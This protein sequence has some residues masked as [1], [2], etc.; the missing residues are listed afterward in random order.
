MISSLPININDLLLFH[1][2]ESARTEFKQSWDEKTTGVQI[3]KTICA[4]A[5]DFY[6]V[7]GGY[8][9]IGVAET[10]GATI[11]PP[12]GLSMEELN[13]AQKWIRGNCKR[14][15]PKVQLRLSPE[16]VDGQHILVVWIPGSDAR[17]H[18]APSGKNQ[19]RAY[20]I[21]EGSETIE[22][23]GQ[24]LTE[25]LNLCA[26]IPF[27]DRRA[28]Q[29]TLNDLRSILVRE[30]LSEVDSGLLEEKNDYK[31]YRHLW[32]TAKTNGHE[33][34]KNVALLFFT[35]DP[36]IAF[37][38]AR[39]EVVY[40]P[41]DSSGNLLQEWIFKGPLPKQ[42]KD[43]INHLEHFSTTFI[44]K[45]DDHYKANRWVTFPLPA[46]KESIVNAVYHRS[47][48]GVLEPTKVYIYPDRIE[49]TSY[50]GPVPGLTKNHFEH[51]KVPAVPA[52]N[53]RIGEM[54]KELKLA[55]ARGTGIH[56]IYKAMLTNGS[57]PPHYDFD[58]ERTYFTVILPA[59][60]AITF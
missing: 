59:H 2:V 27:D 52:R 33:V 3:L 40:F 39:I 24:F 38:G 21:R 56:K 1:G 45:Q 11:L 19:Q 48:E 13:I 29:F 18:Q 53:R 25:L 12:L 47:Y 20:Y 50:P 57:P 4:F 30:F 17:P 42:I 54:L 60:P 22:A 34:P 7:N 14:L 31:I 43:C 5:N 8:I 41:E 16:V 9:I 35:D 6:N 28:S 55:E 44:Q 36:E 15:E 10:E 32:I 26:K 37:R 46:L 49:I 23:K 58:E 51:Q